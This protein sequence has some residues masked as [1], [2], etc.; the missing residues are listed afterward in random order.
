[1]YIHFPEV[2]AEYGLPLQLFGLRTL[3]QPPTTRELE[4]CKRTVNI[5]NR[6]SKSVTDR[7]PLLYALP[8]I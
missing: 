4:N 7:F 5:K 8:F 2:C 1:M 6:C 3:F